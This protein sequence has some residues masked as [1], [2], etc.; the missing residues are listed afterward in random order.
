MFDRLPVRVLASIDDDGSENLRER[1]RPT[2]APGNEAAF[3]RGSL[4]RA[5]E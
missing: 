5:S 4:A 3:E 1:L 2:T